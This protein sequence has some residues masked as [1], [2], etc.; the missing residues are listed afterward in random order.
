MTEI[1]DEEFEF[2]TRWS[3]DNPF[4]SLLLYFLRACQ[5]HNK[6]HEIRDQAG[7][8]LTKLGDRTSDLT[9][10]L[11]FWLSSLYVV[12]EGYRELGFEDEAID[13]LIQQ[14]SIE[15]LRVF[16]NGSFHF[17]R[18]P[19]KNVQFFGGDNLN[20]AEALHE[21]FKTFFAGPPEQSDQRLSNK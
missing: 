17:Q 12:C 10:Y 4:G 3:N 8:D 19:E 7:G 1:D 16:R 13:A 9:T 2:I 14:P 20:W 15:A 21:E 18:N 11:T 5:M 6:V